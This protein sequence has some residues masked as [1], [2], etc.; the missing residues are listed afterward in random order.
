MEEVTPKGAPL[1]AD[2]HVYFLMNIAPPPGMEFSYSH[3]L[4]LPPEQASKLHIISEA[5]L[6][7]QVQ[8]G[9]YATL[10]TC[11]DDRVDDWDLGRAFNH[12]A[13]L[14]DCY[15]FWEVNR[16]AHFERDKPLP[17]PKR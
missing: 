14:A 5:Q 1:F 13:E 7:Q 3:K 12:R 16:E 11:S 8:K 15:V 10:E 6:K 9:Q 2:E 17:K 4:Q